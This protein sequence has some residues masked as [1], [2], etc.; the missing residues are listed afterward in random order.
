M[1]DVAFR[2]ALKTGDFK[3]TFVGS[4]VTIDLDAARWKTSDLNKFWLESKLEVAPP[5]IGLSRSKKTDQDLSWMLVRVVV[6]DNSW[7]R[8]A[9]WKFHAP[10]E[11]K[12]EARRLSQT[13]DWWG[14]TVLFGAD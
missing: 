6:P 13:R 8:Y 9:C 11:L 1:A 4:H 12:D 5:V 3:Y 2:A 10:Q 14:G 7:P